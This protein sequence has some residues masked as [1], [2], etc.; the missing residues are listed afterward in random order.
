MILA[1][2]ADSEVQHEQVQDRRR[3]GPLA[4]W[5]RRGGSG[6]SDFPVWRRISFAQQRGLFVSNGSW[7]ILVVQSWTAKE[8]ERV[9]RGESERCSVGEPSSSTSAE[10]LSVSFTFG[11]G[12]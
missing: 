8:I 6:S 11:E 4:G 12:I 9:A 10:P 2:L 1:Q 5:Y 3:E 7:C